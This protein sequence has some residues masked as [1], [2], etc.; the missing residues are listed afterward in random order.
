MALLGRKSTLQDST[1]YIFYRDD[2][3]SRVLDWSHVVVSILT[4]LA[5]FTTTKPDQIQHA[6]L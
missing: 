2:S 3:W 4:S 5:G 6:L 1:H